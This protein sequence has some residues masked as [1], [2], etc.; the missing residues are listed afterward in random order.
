MPLAACTQ[1]ILGLVPPR[2]FCD[3]IRPASCSLVL[4]P[5]LPRRDRFDISFQKIDCLSCLSLRLTF[6]I[7]LRFS[8]GRVHIHEHDERE[9]EGTRRA[10]AWLVPARLPYVLG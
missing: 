3:R 2:R 9:G 5:F 6:S 4:V 8:D 10:R 7:L 1:G